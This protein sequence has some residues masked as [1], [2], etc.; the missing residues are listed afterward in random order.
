[1]PVR[2]LRAEPHDEAA[3]SNPAGL[4]AREVEI[5]RMVAS[6]QSSKE[7]AANLVLSARTVERHIQNVYT[8]I[9]AHGRA[10]ATSFAIS[11]G[12]V[13]VAAD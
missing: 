4:S 12:L 11:A 5:L 3:R 8:K 1:V 9:G 6:G 13:G 2:R 10:E 7:I